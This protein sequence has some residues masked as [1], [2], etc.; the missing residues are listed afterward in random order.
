V[1]GLG[2][3]FG[4]DPGAVRAATAIY[5]E[6]GS[7]IRTVIRYQIHDESRADDLYQDFFVY[8]VRN[9]LPANI[10]NVR[11]YLYRALTHDAV[12]FNRRQEKY[13]RHLKKHAEDTRISINKCTPE[14]A[15]AG[16]EQVSV[17]FSCLGWYLRP[18]EAEVVRL[19]YRD[20]LSIPEIAAR[21]DVDRRTVSRYLCAGLR[22]LREALGIE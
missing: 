4:C 20:G 14:D 19:R 7:F 16:K 12:D 3:I 10:R 2:N 5:A 1:D 22:T 18:R 15:I 9:P 17:L 11:S 13:Q 6:Q 21:L 8:L